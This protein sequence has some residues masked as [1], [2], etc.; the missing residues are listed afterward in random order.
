MIGAAPVLVV[1]TLAAVSVSPEA[2]LCELPSDCDAGVCVAGWC[3]EGAD[4]AHVENLHTIAVPPP[5]VVAGRARLAEEGRRLGEQI[6]QDLV[7]TGFYTVLPAQGLPDGWQREGVSP[8]A[9]RRV[10]WQRAG[11]T[12]VVQASLVPSVDPGSYRLRIRLVEIE[13]YAT[14]D[15][16]EGDVLVRPGGARRAV[17]QWVDA[18]VERD[19]GLGGALQARIAA[20]VMLRPGIKEIA[21]MDAD[22]GAFGFATNNGSLN[23]A[24][25]WGPGGGI[26][27]MSYASGNP[28]WVVDGLPLST[29]PGLNAAGAWSPD[30]RLLAL[31]VA[32]GA[33]SD[34]MLLDAE[35][36]DEHLRLTDHPAVDTSPAWSPDGRRLAF[37]S[38]RTGSPQIWIASLDGDRQL[39]RLTSGGYITSP[40]WSPL[41]D[42]IV[43]TQQVGGGFAI[44][45]RDLDTGRTSRLTSGSPTTESPSFSPD[46]RY[47]VYARGNGKRSAELW[48]MDAD[49]E[50]AR[51][52]GAPAR[53]TFSPAWQPLREY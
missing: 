3:R 32:E 14:L 45:R 15:L 17:A 6:A 34:V 33:N 47:I 50:R 44:V 30:G 1:A 10:A 35:T 31:S 24:P 46:G 39:R 38:D 29:R 5:L 21:V 25:S 13:R 36:G 28:D 43:Y 18:L 22:G 4:R 7:W 20:T 51:P 52:V 27:Y 19:T 37:V 8:S 2:A 11:A 48:V 49:G 42:S 9:V 12:R 41:G 23:L 40:D 53:P 26:G 16:P